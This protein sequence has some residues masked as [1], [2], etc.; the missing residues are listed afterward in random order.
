M[1]FV[2]VK[3]AA[4]QRAD[5]IKELDERVS[6]GSTD[7][8]TDAVRNL[9]TIPRPP[10]ALLVKAAASPNLDVAREAQQA[11]DEH[12]KFCQREVTADR[13]SKLVSRQLA[14]LAEALAIER[15]LFSVTDYPWVESTT[16]KVLRL[17][18]K[19]PSKTTP[20]VAARCDEILSAI[21]DGVT[22]AT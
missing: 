22:A 5:V 7:E 8:A 14:V 4:L 10:L 11:I 18:N 6:H 1:F 19:I 3:L 21:S 20:L 17:A 13:N 15:H 9:A 2:V 12:L 16:R